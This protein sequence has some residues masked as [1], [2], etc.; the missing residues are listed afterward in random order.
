MM[1]SSNRSTKTLFIFIICLTANGCSSGQSSL[2]P[3]GDIIAES[4]VGEKII[5][6][7]AT[8]SVSIFDKEKKA[9]DLEKSNAESMGQY[10]TCIANLDSSTCWEIWGKDMVDAK[11]ISDTRLL[12]KMKTV[13]YRTISVDVDGHKTASDYLS[14]T[15]LPDGK[16]EDRIRWDK[17]VDGATN[18]TVDNT[19]GSYAINQLCKRYG[20]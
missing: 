7:P 16:Q 1:S 17:L 14:V 5:I 10:N 18:V 9:L 15:C 20:N 8:V 19:V 6:K 13:R 2:A 4:D 12:P 11:T 3:Q